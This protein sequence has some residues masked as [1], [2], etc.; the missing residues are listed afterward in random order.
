MEFGI[1]AHCMKAT[2]WDDLCNQL[3]YRNIRRLQLSL[4]KLTQLTPLKAGAFSPGLASY[5]GNRLRK[6]NIHISVLGCYIDPVHP[7][8]RVRR[9]QL[10]LFKE[11]MLYAKFLEADVVATE[12][13]VL[14]NTDDREAA[15][16]ILLDSMQDLMMHAEK[17]G[18]VIAIEGASVHTVHSPLQMRRLLDDIP[19]PNLGV[20]FDHVGF[21]NKSNYQDQFTIIEE[22]FRL[23]GDK[24]YAVH[25]KDFMADA[26]SFRTVLAGQGMTDMKHLLSLIQQK[27]PHIDVILERATEEQYVEIMAAL[28]H[29]L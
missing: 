23:F 15:Y 18:I 11:H 17:L 29:H 13:G 19:S 1:A 20:I 4:T 12:T 26:A 21:L 28:Q 10:A 14:H 5:I 6:S 25:L 9:A 16:R 7:D 8:E 3:E 22:S 27:K 24:I 2:S